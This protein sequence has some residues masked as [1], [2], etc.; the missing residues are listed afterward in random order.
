[1]R[2]AEQ[3]SAA[4]VTCLR[5]HAC[6]CWSAAPT[7]VTRRSQYGRDTAFGS[8]TTK[9]A[10]GPWIYQRPKSR[11]SFLNPAHPD[12]RRD[13]YHVF[14][15]GP[16]GYEMSSRQYDSGLVGLEAGSPYL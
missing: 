15:L 10:N 12:R 2:D 7:L 3:F 8:G 9:A 1:M 13:A 4:A 11:I 5:V 14:A 6:S 16:A